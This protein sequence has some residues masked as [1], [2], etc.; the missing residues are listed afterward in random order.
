MT[1]ILLNPW[2][3]QLYESI[4]VYISIFKS[5]YFYSWAQGKPLFLSPAPSLATCFIGIERKFS[6]NLTPT[7]LIWDH[8]SGFNKKSGMAGKNTD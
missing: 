3:L 2:R 4:Y 7:C 6:T 5:F 1:F 8:L